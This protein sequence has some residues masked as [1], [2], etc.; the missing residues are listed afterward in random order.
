MQLKRL[1]VYAP[2]YYFPIRQSW[3]PYTNPEIHWGIRYQ[4]WSDRYFGLVY[5]VVRVVIS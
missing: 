2:G 5:C 4:M 3:Q 1:T